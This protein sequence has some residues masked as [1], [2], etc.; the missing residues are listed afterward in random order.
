MLTVRDDG[1]GFPPAVLAGIGKPYNTSKERRGAGLGLF[2]A[3][4]VL[5]TL[6]GTLAARNIA[7]GAEMVL[8]LPVAALALEDGA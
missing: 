5:R 2:L 3:T 6:G 7:G 1:S 4:N 8:R